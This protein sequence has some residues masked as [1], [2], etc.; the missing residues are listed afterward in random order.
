[1]KRLFIGLIVNLLV[2]TAVFADCIYNGKAYPE[3][4]VIGP[5]V[6]SGE[7]WVFKK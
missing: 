2:S 4:T 1:M 7:E 5:Y 6:C 3:K